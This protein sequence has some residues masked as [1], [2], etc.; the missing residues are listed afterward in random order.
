[1][2]LAALPE[3]TMGMSFVLS[4]FLRYLGRSKGRP[5]P[6]KIISI[7]LLRPF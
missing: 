6:E 3:D 7:F 2:I 1:M 4:P 5:A